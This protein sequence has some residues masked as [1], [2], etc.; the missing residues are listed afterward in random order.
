MDPLE[1]PAALERA[2]QGDQ[3]ALGDLLESFRPYVRALTR[4]LGRERVQSRLG[5]SDL[6]Q[7]ALVVAHQS[8]AG[9]RG[10]TVAEL[11]SWLRQIVLRSAGHTLRDHLGRAKRAA[12]RELS[13]DDLAAFLVD[14]GTSPS[15]QAIRHEQAAQLAQV[16]AE[17]PE[18]MQ[19][20]LLW[21]H[22]D[23]LAHADIAARLERT[24][25]AARALYVRAL[26][27]L[28]DHWQE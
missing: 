15:G 19:Q 3:Q 12:N 23:G 22:V 1:R 6:I 11:T 18:D 17:M 26:R 10:T 5:A 24:E 8:F 20:V 2:R 7:D 28:R 9:F 16:L 14:T 27:K 13:A 21:R 25:E 4:T